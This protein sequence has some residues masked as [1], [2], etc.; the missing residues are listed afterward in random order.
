[1]N[2]RLALRLLTTG[3][4]LVAIAIGLFGLVFGMKNPAF[5]V[6]AVAAPAMLDTALRYY[7]GLWL[8]VGLCSLWVAP[9]IEREPSLFRALWAMVFVGG[10]GRIISLAT[11][12]SAGPLF[13]VFMIIEVVGGPSILLLHHRSTARA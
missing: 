12:G 2:V 5:G 7:A 11:V 6:S 4:G 3:L 9:R 13:I 8:G 1:M 10:I